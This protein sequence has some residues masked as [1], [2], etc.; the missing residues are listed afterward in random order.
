M[1]PQNSTHSIETPHSLPMEPGSS[2]ELLSATHVFT[3][4][5]VKAVP[6]SWS[7]WENGLQHRQVNMHVKLLSIF[8]GTL[9][10]HPNESFDLPVQQKREGEFVQSDYHGLWSHVSVESGNRYLVISNSQMGS[11]GVLMQEPACQQ[12]LPANYDRDVLSA[13]EGETI[14]VSSLSAKAPRNQPMGLLR[15]LDLAHR[16]RTHTRK[17]FAQ[18]LWARVRPTFSE[19]QESFLPSVLALIT[20][21]NSTLELR[22]SLIADLYETTLTLNSPEL[23][24]RVLKTFL[25]LL[26]QKSALSLQG[27]LAEVQIYN[28][29]FREGN[30]PVSSKTVTPGPEAVK[31]ILATLIGLGTDRSNQLVKW[32]SS[33]AQ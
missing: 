11:P 4:E 5:I 29:V 27:R 26:T 14:Y 25:L 18:Y 28:L 31:P 24:T 20:D 8:K 17:I 19:Y 12:L 2:S 3:V 1:N 15:L 32:L 21:E 33:L 13:M 9:D 22:E 10:L 16:E 30:S 23:T 6:S 7:A